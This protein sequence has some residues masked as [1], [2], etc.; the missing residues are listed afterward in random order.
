MRIW[1]ATR[2]AQV[3]MD[4][5]IINNI[6]RVFSPSVVRFDSSVPTILF[7]HL[8]TMFFSWRQSVRIASFLSDKY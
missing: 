2:H 3:A 7:Y 1:E 4:G 6:L 5:F 8:L